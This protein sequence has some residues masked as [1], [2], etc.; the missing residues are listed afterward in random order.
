M[1]GRFAADSPVEEAVTSEPVSANG[2]F[3]DPWENTAYFVGPAIQ[4]WKNL[5][6]A[7]G[8]Q[9]GRK[10]FPTGSNRELKLQSRQSESGD[11]ARLYSGQGNGVPIA[12]YG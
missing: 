4:R 7:R 12:L 5:I 6:F 8:F 11:Q 3:P 2:V 10:K 1:A 9:L